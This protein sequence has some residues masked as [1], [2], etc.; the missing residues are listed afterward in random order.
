MWNYIINPSQFITIFAYNFKEDAAASLYSTLFYNNGK[1][2]EIRGL[3]GDN[4]FNWYD[5]S[6]LIRDY[7]YTLDGDSICAFTIP[8]GDGVGMDAVEVYAPYLIVKLSIVGLTKMELLLE[9]GMEQPNSRFG[10]QS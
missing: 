5:N 2:K 1:S 3:G 4:V 8:T 6:V 7:C 10:L 9:G